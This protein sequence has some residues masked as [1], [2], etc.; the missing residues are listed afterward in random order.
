[1]TTKLLDDLIVVRGDEW[2]IPLR[3]I[4]ATTKEPMDLTGFAVLLTVTRFKGPS[5]DSKKVFDCLGVVDPD[6]VLNKG[7]VTFTPTQADTA[8][9]GEYYYDIQISKNTLKKTFNTGKKCT[10][11][12]DH[13]K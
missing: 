7:R 3:I 4:G 5:D 6:Q 12:Q 2:P 9:I 11:I 10:I 8:E 13:G 1:L